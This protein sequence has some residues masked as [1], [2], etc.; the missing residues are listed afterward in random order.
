MFVFQ[1]FVMISSWP[2]PFVWHIFIL[3]YFF[4]DFMNLSIII[5]L[6]N[7]VTCESHVDFFPHVHTTTNFYD[8]LLCNIKMF[9]YFLLL[10]LINIMCYKKNVT[11]L[12]IFSFMFHRRNHSRMKKEWVNYFVT[13]FVSE[14]FCDFVKVHFTV[15]FKNKLLVS[16]LVN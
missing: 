11:F 15:L 9:I 16:Y 6:M 3:S 2:E 8:N 5:L 13:F 4:I 12:K 10:P 7:R 1:R 14:L